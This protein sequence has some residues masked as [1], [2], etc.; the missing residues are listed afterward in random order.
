MTKPTIGWSSFA[1]TRHK[2]GAGYSFFTIS[3]NEVV[4][5]VHKNWD[6]RQPGHGETGLDRKIVVPITE[7]L[8]DNTFFIPEVKLQPNLPLRSHMVTRQAGEDP[9]VET[10]IDFDEAKQLGIKPLAAKFVKIVCYSAEALLEN[11]GTRTT[12]DD[13]EIVAV[14]AEVSDDAPP[15]DALTMARNY[16]EKS[17]GTK[18]VYTAKEFAEAVYNRATNRTIKIKKSE[19]PGPEQLKVLK[20]RCSLLIEQI[21]NIKRNCKHKLQPL[22]E[23]K[24]NYADCMYC[25]ESLGSWRC[26]Q[27]PDTVCHTILDLA[28]YSSTHIQLI[29]GST[30]ELT[31]DQRDRGI[32]PELCV[33]CGEPDERK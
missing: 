32:D 22:G 26:K 3:N 21:E 5:L 23:A 11:N 27:S 19:L 18:S 30:V 1:N 33:F 14:L 29:D 8:A 28:D 7:G 6:H 2:E 17:G 31:H 20:Q 24:H 13:W 15:M 25:G 16:L 9:Y 12:D 4:D 10:Y